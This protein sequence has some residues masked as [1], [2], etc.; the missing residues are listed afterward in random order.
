MIIFFLGP[1]CCGKNFLMHKLAKEYNYRYF[2]S[3]RSPICNLVYDEIYKRDNVQYNIDLI[4]NLLRLGAVFILIKVEPEI[5]LKRA[6][7]R[8]EEHVTTLSDFKKHIK[9]YS[10]VFDACKS[11][12]HENYSDRFIEFNNSNTSSFVDFTKLKRKL[13]NIKD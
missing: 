13:K 8:N 10:S 7:A 1:D 9:V 3:P 4:T 6:I 5:L 11:V 12:W 2:M